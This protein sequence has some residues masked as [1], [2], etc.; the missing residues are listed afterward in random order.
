M[1]TNCMRKNF[2]LNTVINIFERDVITLHVYFIRDSGRNYS[3]LNNS[4]HQVFSFQDTLLFMWSS[5]D[6]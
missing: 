6:L 3:V 1:R 4:S 2:P 5:L